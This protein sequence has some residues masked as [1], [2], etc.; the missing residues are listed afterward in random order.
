MRPPRGGQTAR[1]AVLTAA[2]VVTTAGAAAVAAPGPAL[3][4]VPIE[5][6]AQSGIDIVPPPAEAVRETG[7]WF[8]HGTTLELL[9]DGSGTFARWVGAFDGDRIALRL[10]PAPGEATVAEIIG[11]ETVGEGALAPGA[12]PGIGGLVTI[13]IGEGVRTAHVEWTSGP[14]R[15]SVDLCPAEGLDAATM[16]TLRCGA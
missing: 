9:P 6:S 8:A 7:S 13:S 10:I 3:P 14:E 2:L 4:G 12:R 1:R 15:L 11:I 5:V 16:E